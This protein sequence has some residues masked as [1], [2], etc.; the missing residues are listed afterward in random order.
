MIDAQKHEFCL[1]PR[2]VVCLP[3]DMIAKEHACRGHLP[4]HDSDVDEIVEICREQVLT[5][6]LAYDRHESLTSRAVERIAKA[7]KH[8]DASCFETVEVRPVVHDTVQVGL[9]GAN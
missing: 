8:V 6:H 2:Q 3:G 4:Q 1:P 5:C 9:I 7:T